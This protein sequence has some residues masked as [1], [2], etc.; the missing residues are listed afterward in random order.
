M[1]ANDSYFTDI[2]RASF[3]IAW[4]ILMPLTGAIA[5]LLFCLFLGLDP[6]QEGNIPI[7]IS[8]LV[9][10]IVGSLLKKR[11]RAKR[12]RDDGPDRV[13]ASS[14]SGVNRILWSAAAGLLGGMTVGYLVNVITFPHKTS[15]FFALVNGGIYGV[16]GAVVGHRYS[17]KV[18]D[19]P[20]TRG[21]I[22]FVVGFITAFYINY[23]AMGG[24]LHGRLRAEYLHVEHR[25]EALAAVIE[26]FKDKNGRYPTSEEGLSILP[27]HAGNIEGVRRPYHG[28]LKTDP[29]K[30][31]GKGELEYGTRDPS[32]GFIITS[33]GPD[34]DSDI[35]EESYLPGDPE[36]VGLPRSGWD[37]TSA[38]YRS[39]GMLVLAPDGDIYLTERSE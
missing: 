36:S 33:Y 9:F 24:A 31:G 37:G 11:W 7:G 3:E 5:G 38:S 39:I 1:K 18:C 15:L 2:I 23:F 19:H 30:T 22:L 32:K 25:M 4:I 14:S 17:Q 10:L 20:L 34:G 35:E 21:L 6:L 12:E 29:F 13:P 26:D 28:L 16:I 8:I 27:D